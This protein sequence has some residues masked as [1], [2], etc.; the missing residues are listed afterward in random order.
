MRKL[1]ILACCLF[2]CQAGCQKPSPLTVEP[3]ADSPAGTLRV[4]VLSNPDTNIAVTPFDSVGVLPA[5]QTT[6][7]GLFLVNTVKY[8]NGHGT[9]SVAYASAYFGDRNRPLVVNGKTIGYYGIDLMPFSIYPLK[10]GG[11]AMVRY[12]YRIHIGSRD[13]TFGYMYR[14][15]FASLQPRNNYDWDDPRPDTTRLSS[16]HDTVVTPEDL[17]VL[18]PAGGSVLSRTKQLVL[19]WNGSGNLAIVISTLNPLTGKSKPILK[20]EPDV[21]TG[22]AVIDPRVLQMLPQTRNFVFTFIIAN[23]AE[24]LLG[25]LPKDRVLVQA[26]SVYNSYLQLE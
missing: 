3:P 10:I 7:S 23:K 13:T 26:A 1:S 2:L 5:D 11:I 19:R 16:F 22:T 24:R 15:V 12:P 25:G 17:K 20:L 8:D 21:N 6:Y 18:A 14:A 4:T 9:L